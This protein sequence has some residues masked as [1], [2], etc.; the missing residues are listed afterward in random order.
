MKCEE[1]YPI[2]DFLDFNDIGHRNVVWSDFVHP[3]FS[4]P[5]HCPLCD[6]HLHLVLVALLKQQTPILQ[7]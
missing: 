5:V 2:T 7:I 1:G 6:H 4:V 3:V